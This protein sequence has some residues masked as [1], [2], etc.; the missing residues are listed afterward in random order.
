METLYQIDVSIFRLINEAWANPFF[1][2]L[3]P[4][5]THLKRSWPITAAA[6]LFVLVRRR[7]DGL[8]IV[9]LSVLAVAVA[10]QTASGLFKPLVQRTRPCFELENVRLLIDQVRSYS[11]A[12]SHAANSFAVATMTWIYFGKSPDKLDKAFAWFMIV[13]ASINSY[14]RVYIGVH[15]P[16]DVLGGAAMGVVSAIL[17]YTLFAF[18]FKNYLKPRW[19]ARRMK[20]MTVAKNAIPDTPSLADHAGEQEKA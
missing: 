13:Y 7:W 20:R 17:I 4:F 6:I 2:V 11:F 12:S 19:D 8:S 9:L 5:A 18:L 1:D 15:Y 14:S 3:M 16:S 10:D